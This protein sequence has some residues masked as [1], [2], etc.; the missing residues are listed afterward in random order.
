MLK[1][2]DT[3]FKTMKR[4]MKLFWTV[5]IFNKTTTFLYTLDSF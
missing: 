1:I 3:N 2:T 4:I 5:H